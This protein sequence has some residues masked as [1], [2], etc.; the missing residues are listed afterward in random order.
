VRFR[1]VTVVA[2]ALVM[3]VA[4]PAAALRLPGGGNARTDCY[5]GFEVTGVA[6]ATSTR[7]VECTDG[8]PTCDLD[9]AEN[10]SCRFEVAACLNS[11]NDRPTCI[12]PAPPAA[13]TK[14]KLRRAAAGLGLPA[15]DAADC[16][17][18]QNID[19]AVKVR[20]N[21]RKRPGKTV[22]R[23]VAVSPVKP[24]R[25]KDKARLICNPAGTLSPGAGIRCPANPAGPNEPNE[26]LLTVKAAGT[27]LD[28]GWKG[29]SFNFPTPAG[30]QLQMCLQDCDSA[31]DPTCATRVPSGEN[32]FNRSTFGPPL[33]L[34]TAGVPVCVINEFAPEQAS[35]IGSADLST[36]AVNG[37][38]RL[39]SHVYLTEEENVCPRCNNG[40]CN[41]GPR[42]GQTCNVDG[43]VTVSES[44]AANKNFTLSKDCPPPTNA[45]AGTLVINLPLTTGTSTLDP[46]AGGSVQTPCVAQQAEAA[47]IRPQPDQ[48]SAGAQ[49]IAQCG[50]NAC[51]SMGQDPVTGAPVCVDAKGGL[52]QFCCSNDPTRPCHPTGS[53]AR[54]ERTGTATVPTPAWPDP[55]YP[56]TSD[57]VTVATFCEAATGTGS[58]DGLTGLPGPGAIILPSEAQWLA[59]S[60]E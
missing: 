9:G 33:P 28:N 27:D 8:D 16:G 43:R 7:V 58:V 46:N 59:P 26:L 51:A 60:P 39:L 34:F 54:I 24:K 25:D 52:S 45:P 13:L 57:V 42:A 38:I 56:K 1:N 30:T 14:V 47:G 55:T 32:T 44:S 31:T 20:R 3:L 35:E 6:A 40:R 19:V 2:A 23:G 49:C 37:T 53:G 41:S 21:G 12:P 5:V 15:L 48:C 18:A 36:G 4:L 50:G 29:P 17:P 22:L 10:D 11:P